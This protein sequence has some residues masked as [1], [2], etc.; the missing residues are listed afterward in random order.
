MVTSSGRCWSLGDVRPRKSIQAIIGLQRREMNFMQ[1]VY[2]FF[3]RFELQVD[4]F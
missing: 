4:V 2:D 1:V 3:M